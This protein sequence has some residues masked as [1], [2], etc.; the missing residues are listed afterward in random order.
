[1]DLI[2]LAISIQT[3]KPRLGP[4]PRGASL[5]RHFLGPGQVLVALVGSEVT[6]LTLNPQAA[7]KVP[8]LS[9]GRH[10]SPPQLSSK[11]VVTRRR[12]P[13]N[14]AAAQLA[15]ALLKTREARR[16]SPLLAVAWPGFHMFQ[17]HTAEVLADT[18]VEALMDC[19]IDHKVSTITIYNCTTN[20]AVINHLLQKLPTKAMPLDGKEVCHILMGVAV[21]LDPRYKMYL[22]EFFFRK[23]YH[24][25]ARFKIDEVRQNCYDLLFDYQSRCCTLNESSS[26]ISGLENTMQSDVHSNVN[27][28]ESLDEFEQ[29]VVSKT[30]GATNLST[31]S[32][33]DMYL[34]ESLL[35]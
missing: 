9:V 13:L 24:E 23:F 34:D 18:L 2:G 6:R 31:M 30:S 5:Q 10:E 27:V 8:H 29:F 17:L 35:P 22:V 32:E 20:D 33:L 11:F 28:D 25:S 16:R 14:L 21:V 1:M 4:A 12:S 19:N 26:S 7:E 3:R 15:V